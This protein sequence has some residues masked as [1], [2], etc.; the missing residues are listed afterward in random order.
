MRTG[1]TNWFE[2]I[3]TPNSNAVLIGLA[4]VAL[5]TT[6]ILLLVYLTG[7]IKFSFSHTIYFPLTLGAV[8]LGWRGGQALGLVAGIALGPWM[9]L[10]SLTGE[11]QNTF[12]WLYRLLVLV[13]LGIFI[14]ALA[15]SMRKYLRYIRWISYHDSSSGLPNRSALE[16]ELNQLEKEP[17]TAGCDH[18]LIIIA[19]DNASEIES[20]FGS[21]AVNQILSELS[22]QTSGLITNGQIYRIH[23]NQLALLHLN[24]YGDRIVNSVESLRKA[25]L[26]P[27]LF[28]DVY[29]HA[30]VEFGVIGIKA[31]FEEPLYYIQRAERSEFNAIESGRVDVDWIITRDNH[32]QIGRNLQLLGEL[33]GAIQDRK[34]ELHFQPKI[35]VSSGTSSGVEALLRWHRADG[36]Y[37]PPEWIIP[38]AEQSTLIDDI[39]FFTIDETLRN[40]R[41]W[42][43]DGL[44]AGRVAINISARSLRQPDFIEKVMSRLEAWSL[45][46]SAIEMEL[47]ETAFIDSFD[48]VSERMHELANQGIELTI[49]DFGTGY[50]SLQYLHKLPISTLKIDRAFVTHAS[51][52]RSTACILESTVKLAQNLGKKVVAEGVESIECLNHLRDIGCDLAQGFYLCKPLQSPDLIAWLKADA[53]QSRL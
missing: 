11:P 26:R 43:E 30:D 50:A 33:H 13:L 15:D 29:V 37:I 42:Q 49:D 31:P 20:V 22:E 5:S 10:D 25:S 6:G 7:G 41:L 3:E 19:L 48:L 17:L 16:R 52:L 46:S 18:Y 8:L 21:D 45:P 23:Y 24:T 4:L 34:L 9:P 38:R 44:S 39:T 12:N 36:S 47:T 51:Q 14:G 28:E 2:L 40:I 1:F 32:E 53:L 35:S 27:L